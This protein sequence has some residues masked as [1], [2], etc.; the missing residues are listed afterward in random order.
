[1]MP[2]SRIASSA[3][4]RPQ[5]GQHRRV[6]AAADA[7]AVQPGVHLDG[8]VGGDAGAAAPRPAA[9]RAGAPRTRAICDIG[10]QRGGEVGARRMQPGQHRRGDAVAAQRQR[11]VDGGDAEFGRARGQ[12]GPGDLG[13]AVAVAVGLD[14]GHHLRR[15]GVLAQHP[16]VVRD[17]AEVH[18]RLGVALGVRTASGRCRHVSCHRRSIVPERASASGSASVSAR[19]AAAGRNGR[20]A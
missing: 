18:H 12:R 2:R 9:R 13:G 14:D 15:T 8:D 4:A 6:S 16:H 19:S 10:L 17:R 1:M 3:T 5:R 11:L 20:P 7:V